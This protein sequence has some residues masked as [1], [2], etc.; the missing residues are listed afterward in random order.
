[1][2]RRGAFESLARL[3]LDATLTPRG[4]RLT[5]QPPGTV[6]DWEPAAVYEANPDDSRSRW[7]WLAERFSGDVSCV[8]MW[9]RLDA[10]SGRV[11]CNLEGDS[12]SDLLRDVGLLTLARQVN[13]G[14]IAAA[15]DV[16]LAQIAMGLE[17]LFDL[18]GSTGQRRGGSSD[19]TTPYVQAH[20][21]DFLGESEAVCQEL[22][23]ASSSRPA[24]AARI[25]SPTGWTGRGESTMRRQGQPRGPGRRSPARTR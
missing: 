21:A 1:M 15:W 7:P 22:R 23:P 5:A 6:E 11:R 19:E 2:V 8:D 13:C 24:G 16:Q 12:L 4:F 14:E 10:V 9:V 3:Y 18:L 20:E 17:T 25:V